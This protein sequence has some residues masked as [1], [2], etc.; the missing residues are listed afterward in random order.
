[1]FKLFIKINFS[2]IELKGSAIRARQMETIYHQCLG[3][4]NT[5]YLITWFYHSNLVLRQKAAEAH[6]ASY[7]SLPSSLLFPPS[8]SI[9][10]YN[11][12]EWNAV[13]SYP[14]IDDILNK[15]G[16]RAHSI[17]LHH[18]NTKTCKV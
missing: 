6:Y 7:C 17:E 8:Y 4:A 9:Y 15:N 12:G 14:A 1:M 16:K 11:G 5:K 10:Y 2:L 13:I 3:N 18:S